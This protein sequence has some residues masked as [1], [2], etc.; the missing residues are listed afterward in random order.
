MYEHIK[1]YT[2]NTFFYTQHW[3]NYVLL[4]CIVLVNLLFMYLL[5]NIEGVYICVVL[6]WLGYNGFNLLILI[7]ILALYK[8]SRLLSI[9]ICR[10]YLYPARFSVDYSW[11]F[12]CPGRS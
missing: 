4:T 7:L 3:M 10:I 8:Y 5:Q 12:V 1:K 6:R 11:C 9:H 2:K